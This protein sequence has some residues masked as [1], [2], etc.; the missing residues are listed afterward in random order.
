MFYLASGVFVV[1]LAGLYFLGER[2][3][4]DIR[5]ALKLCAPD[6]RPS[7]LRRFGF[8]KFA[9]N[10]DPSLLTEAGRVQLGRAIWSERLLLHWMVDFFLFVVIGVFAKLP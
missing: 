5:L 1:W 8:R 10:I 2:S 4:N 6:T 3:R 7:D 9:S